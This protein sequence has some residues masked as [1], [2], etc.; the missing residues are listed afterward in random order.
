MIGLAVLSP[1]FGRV[2]P[3]DDAV[4]PIL[5]RQSW[6]R[7]M[8]IGDGR[9]HVGEVPVLSTPA[10]DYSSPTYLFLSYVIVRLREPFPVQRL[11]RG[12]ATALAAVPAAFCSPPAMIVAIFRPRNR[13][14]LLFRPSSLWAALFVASRDRVLAQRRDDR[15]QHSR[16]QRFYAH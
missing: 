5:T 2:L 3:V 6:P 10:A 14:S 15:A 4:C 12:K 8:R 11:A 16:T 1:A 13:P 9:H 7:F